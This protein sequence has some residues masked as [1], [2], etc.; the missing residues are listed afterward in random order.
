MPPVAHSCPLAL[1][2]SML[3][4]Q[5]NSLATAHTTHPTRYTHFQVGP[6]AWIPAPKLNSDPLETHEHCTKTEREAPRETET[7]VATR[8]GR[9]LHKSPP[10]TKAT[11]THGEAA[12]LKNWLGGSGGN[13][14]GGMGR[15][16]SGACLR[17]PKDQRQELLV[18]SPPLARVHQNL[19]T[20]SRNRGVSHLR[21]SGSIRGV[22]GSPRTA[23][24]TCFSSC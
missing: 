14:L 3:Q 13:W 11:H 1:Q 12:R 20:A 8:R 10:L 17:L 23:S 16:F 2:L 22:A 15:N 5:R 4:P 19:P 24:T 21:S 18:H 6:R 7:E 9:M